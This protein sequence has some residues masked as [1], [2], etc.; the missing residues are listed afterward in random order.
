[1][2][3]YNHSNEPTSAFASAHT[4]KKGE[5]FWLAQISEFLLTQ[6][7]SPF[8]ARRSGSRS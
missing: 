7:Y 6:D 8:A 4:N 5:P 1:M 2:A 3:Q